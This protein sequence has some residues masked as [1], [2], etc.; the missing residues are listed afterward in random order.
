MKLTVNGQE[1]VLEGVDPT[2]SRHRQGRV[3]TTRPAAR[4][5]TVQAPQSACPHPTLFLSDQGVSDRPQERH[6]R[7]NPF[8]DPLC[9][10]TV[11]FI[12]QPSLFRFTKPQRDRQTPSQLFLKE[13]ASIAGH[14]R[15][16]FLSCGDPA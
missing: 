2:M 10:L 4:H 13:R 8:Q 6:R 1:R 5:G 15:S 14:W 11:S 12:A 16:K 3:G 7:V 9:P